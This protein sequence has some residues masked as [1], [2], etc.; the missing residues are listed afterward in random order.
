M[1]EKERTYISNYATHVDFLV[2]NKLTKMPV[3]AVETD[4]YAFHN[5]KTVQHLRDEMKN[6][7]F[8]VYGIPL[9]RLST[10]G[11]SERERVINMLMRVK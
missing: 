1:S 11:S 9:L 7:V 4:G 6:H 10:K 8:E 5:E 2:V 3:M